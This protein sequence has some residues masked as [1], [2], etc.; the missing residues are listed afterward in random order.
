[1]RTISAL[2]ALLSLSIASAAAQTPEAAQLIGVTRAVEVAEKATSARALE[3]DL[4]GYNGR[5]VY[6]IELVRD[7]RLHRV[8]V[9]A[10]T[11]VVISKTAP[12]IE[13][14]W[15]RVFDAKSLGSSDV[16]SLTPILTALEQEKNARVQDVEF[17]NEG[18]VALYEIELETAAGVADVF[19]D[20]RSGEQYTL[21]PRN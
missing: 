7:S 15:R 16:L 13:R 9:D 18:G 4:D 6:E 14:L 3:A 2:I 12:R 10:E 1:M 8:R 21:A 17:E 19:V 20:A 11:G 5:L